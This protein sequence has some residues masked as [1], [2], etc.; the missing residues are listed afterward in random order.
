[1]PESQDWFT[2]IARMKEGLALVEEGATARVI[3]ADGLTELKSAVDHCRTTLWAALLAVQTDANASTAMILAT[4]VQRIREMCERVQ[5]DITEGR[6]W[7]EKLGLLQFLA[8]LGETERSVR[9][10][11]NHSQTG[12]S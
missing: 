12:E 11:L 6:M 3:P 9:A 10:L 7:K 5:E 8:T 1:M 4:R 2:Q